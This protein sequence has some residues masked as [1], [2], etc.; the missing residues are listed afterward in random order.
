MN[1]FGF[2]GSNAHAVLDDAFHYLRQRLLLA[3]HCTLGVSPGLS[4]KAWP[5]SRDKQLSS[6]SMADERI[7]PLEEPN[8]VGVQNRPADGSYVNGCRRQDGVRKTMINRILVWTA[9]DE[10]GI[11]RLLNE[12]QGYFSQEF[13]ERTP[14]G[15]YLEDLAYTLAV[16]R[17]SFQ[18]RS[19]AIVD[20]AAAL[21]NVKN[22][23][24]KPVRSSEKLG[25][26]FIFTGQGAQYK[27]MGAGLLQ[28]PIFEDTL[29]SIETIYR[30]L[31][32]QWSLYG[33]LTFFRR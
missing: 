3:N 25:I 22:L 8:G 5:S 2:G 20:S 12:Y 21:M 9:A 10:A 24:S 7:C 14:D 30:K 32:C 19:F 17:S 6:E 15:R 1:S 28:Y 11:I 29:R 26:A 18:W 13:A 16:R 27:N 23:V 33:M 31:G 4:D